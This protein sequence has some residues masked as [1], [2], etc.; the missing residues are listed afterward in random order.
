M[1]QPLDLDGTIFVPVT[2][3]HNKQAEYLRHFTDKIEKRKMPSGEDME[4]GT[5]YMQPNAGELWEVS[6]E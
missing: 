6:R 3:T 2:L 5:K 1:G 4:L